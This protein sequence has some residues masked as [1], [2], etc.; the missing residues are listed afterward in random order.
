[1]G[2]DDAGEMVVLPHQKHSLA[3]LP[4]PADK[5]P[6]EFGCPPQELKVIQLSRAVFL[7]G[8]YVDGAKT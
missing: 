6:A 5:N 1:M 7:S 4:H 8:D 3:Q 2:I